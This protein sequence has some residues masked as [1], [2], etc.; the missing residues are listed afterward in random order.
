MPTCRKC[1]RQAEEGQKFCEA[2]GEPLR[3]GVAP[4]PAPGPGSPAPISHGKHIWNARIAILVVGL[5]TI[6]LAI[7][8]W[9]SFQGEIEKARAAGETLPG[10]VVT[11]KKLTIGILAAMGLAY[12]G[13]FL[14]ARRNPFAASLV[15]L[16]LFLTNM[17]ADLSINPGFQVKLIVL[18]VIVIFLLFQ[19]VR[20]GLARQKLPKT[21]AK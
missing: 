10:D 7:V 8:F 4:R 15:A 1:G 13:L 11:T 16:I 20:S 6:A 3:G 12:L 9:L 14:W 21:S 2:C 5:F 17:I 19:G 18:N